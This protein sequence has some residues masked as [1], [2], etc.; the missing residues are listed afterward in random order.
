VTIIVDEGTEVE[1]IERGPMAEGKREGLWQVFSSAGELWMEQEFR[2]D[3]LDGVTRIWAPDGWKQ[4]E[5]SYQKGILHGP[6][7]AWNRDGS[8][9]FMIEYANGR[10]QGAWLEMYPGG[11]IKARGYYQND[12]LNS[13]C[14]FF[15]PNGSYDLNKTGVYV[16]GKKVSDR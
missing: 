1:H 14:E 5:R 8:L 10:K 11:S 15:L 9:A 7:T 2:D 4:Q 6:L 16:S 13:Y 12:E 3:Q